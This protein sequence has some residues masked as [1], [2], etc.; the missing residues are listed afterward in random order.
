[1]GTA[2]SRRIRFLIEEKVLYETCCFGLMD[3]SGEVGSAA[4]D[5]ML[6]LLQGELLMSPVLWHRL[7]DNIVTVL[8]V[9]Q[10]WD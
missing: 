4:R 5:I 2:G 1:M 8:P 10:V 9:L 3:S 7:L 6:Y